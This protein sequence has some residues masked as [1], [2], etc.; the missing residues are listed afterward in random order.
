[1]TP[2]PRPLCRLAPLRRL[3]GGQRGQAMTEYVSITTLLLLGTLGGA[4]S[5]PYFR[6][7]IRALDTYLSSVYY[8]LNLP[9]P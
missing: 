9:L 6:L 4:G 5:W 3:L 2:D 7:L 8:T 1:M